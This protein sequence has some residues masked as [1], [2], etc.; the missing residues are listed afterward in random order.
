MSGVEEIGADGAA[1]P[2]VDETRSDEA[3]VLGT[4]RMRHRVR[5]RWGQGV[6]M[7]RNQ[8]QARRQQHTWKRHGRGGI[9]RGREE[10][11]GKENQ[12]CVASPIVMDN[13]E[14]I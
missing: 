14:E 13:G 12:R 3:K 2:C 5:T 11:S 4:Q 10:T 9:E 8:G 7:R 6:S 1:T